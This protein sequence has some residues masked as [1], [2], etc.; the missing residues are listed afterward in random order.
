MP[1]SLSLFGLTPV[2]FAV[3][4]PANAFGSFITVTETTPTSITIATDLT[5]LLTSSSFTVPLLHGYYNPR[6][7]LLQFQGP[8]VESND[9]DGGA[10]QSP[11]ELLVGNSLIDVPNPTNAGTVDNAINWLEPESTPGHPLYD[12][13]V[14]DGPDAPP[15]NSFLFTSDNQVPTVGLQGEAICYG[16]LSSPVDCPI[17]PYGTVINAYYSLQWSV[18]SVPYDHHGPLTITF[19]D[20]SGEVPTPEPTTWFLMLPALGAAAL[21]RR[22]AS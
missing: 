6:A 20:H 1:R 5:G 4:L 19:I 14:F 2:M 22:R 18:S 8:D 16:A 9:S 12:T 21:L 10:G 7:P 13:L 3:F 15:D 11:G 17:V